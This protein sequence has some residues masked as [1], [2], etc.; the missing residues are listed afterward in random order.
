MVEV[1]VFDGVYADRTGKIVLNKNLYRGWTFSEG[2]AV[3]M[4]KG[5]N[6]WGYI[7]IRGEFAIPP[8]FATYPDGYVH[9]FSE[10]L[11][12]IEIKRRFGYIDKTGKFAILP[13]LLDGEDFSD[14]MARVVMEGPCAFNPEGGCGF[15]NPVFPGAEDRAPYDP[16]GEARKQYP[17]CKFTYTDREGRILAQR[18][19]SARDFSEGLAPVRVGSASGFIDKSGMLVIPPK[20]DDAE[21]FHEGLAKVKIKGLY[22]YAD[23]NGIVVI[24][25]QFEEADSFSD[26]LAPVGDSRDRYWYID[27][28]GARAFKGDYLVASTFFKGLAHVRLL[29]SDPASPKALFA[30][31]DTKGRRLFTY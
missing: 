7:D 20:F 10:G 23:K 8:Q 6:L 24:T 30:Y 25:P 26:G 12:K 1:G 18:Y 9:P 14:G 13:Q 16:F 31:I 21:G 19:D 4:R 11:A 22:G 2:L 28:R 17:P 29:R 27:Q 15:A 3:A 5:E